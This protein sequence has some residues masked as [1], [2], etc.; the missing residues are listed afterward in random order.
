MS[1]NSQSETPKAR[2]RRS[3]KWDIIK[4][5]LK[6]QDVR[7]WTAFTGLGMGCVADSW[8]GGNEHSSCTRDGE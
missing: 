1:T 7:V 2:G 6:K 4:W 5:I 3:C 8:E